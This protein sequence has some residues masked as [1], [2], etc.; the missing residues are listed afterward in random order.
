MREKT[1]NP[2][3]ICVVQAMCENPCDIFDAYVSIK[4]TEFFS[5]GMS[6]LAHPIASRMRLHPNHDVL[7]D[8]NDAIHRLKI[9]E[10]EIVLHDSK[11]V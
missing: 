10:G 7:I 11:P 8:R 9:R 4:L 1:I 3:K 5:E 6:S 2:C